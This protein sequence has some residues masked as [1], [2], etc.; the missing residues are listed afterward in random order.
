MECTLCLGQQ[1]VRFDLNQPISIAQPIIPG[2]G[3]PAGTR[4]AVAIDAST[5]EDVNTALRKQA[6]VV[7]GMSSRL[8][9]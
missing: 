5:G 8:D 4:I 9:L 2:S 1:S 6:V 3:D 7:P